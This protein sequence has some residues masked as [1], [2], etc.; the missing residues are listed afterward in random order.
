MTARANLYTELFDTL[1][2][3]R[4]NNAKWEQACVC[5]CVSRDSGQ[6]NFLC[7]K[8][9]GRGFI[10]MPAKSICVGVTTLTAQINQLQI[11]LREPGSAYIT[12]KADVIM[13]YMDRLTFTDFTC[14][15]SEV[16]HWGH[17]D[18]QT[19]DDNPNISPRT[20]RK[21]ESVIY[22]ANDT[23][24]FEENIDF[25]ITDDRY[26]LEWLN[27]ELPSEGLSTGFLY[28]TNPSYLVVDILHELR[29][30]LSDRHVAEDDENGVGITYRELPKQ[31]KLQREDFIYHV[32]EPT[33]ATDNPNNVDEGGDTV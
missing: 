24:S 17:K 12:P 3:D 33:M 25:R 26:H 29:G 10:Y 15:F 11:E 21:I 30:H 13:G 7:P 16:L 19:I 9:G 4:G 1:I 6:P 18:T 32:K 27:T 22:L 31:Y 20:Y 5:S 23:Y 28:L 14:K 2:T 8:C